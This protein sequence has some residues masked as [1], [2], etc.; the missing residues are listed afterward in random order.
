M[1][2]NQNF[3]SGINYLWRGFATLKN[4]HI[5]PF[6]VVPVLINIAL[7]YFG[8]SYLYE[9]FDGW[10]ASFIASTP[11][12]LSFIEWLFKAVFYVAAA[13]L[14]AFGF[15]FAATLIGSPFYGL[16]AE[17]V[18]RINNSQ[19]STEALTITALIKIVP[20]T[21][22]RELQKLLYYVLRL[23]PLAL[24]SLLSLVITPL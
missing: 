8:L 17:Q 11:A 7:F 19:T 21:L 10:L 13:L 12:W 5:L 2:S 24:L 1:Q 9:L 3:Y 22:I 18:E 15:T 6:V 16:M 4:K 20:R 14:V 23:L